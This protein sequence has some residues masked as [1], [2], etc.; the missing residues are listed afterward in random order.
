MDRAAKKFYFLLIDASEA[1]RAAFKK[2]LENTLE[3]PFKIIEASNEIEAI[4]ALHEKSID[5]IILDINLP[6]STGNDFLKT[7]NESVENSI[8]IIIL[9]AH[10]NKNTA[11]T[12]LQAGAKQYL[13][14]SE[15]SDKQLA[16][17]ILN[18]I[19]KQS[20]ESHNIS[21]LIRYLLY[22][23]GLA[24]MLVAGVV[25]YG[26]HI[27][28]VTL[29]QVLPHFPPMQFNTALSF[30]LLGTGILSLNKFPR[31]SLWLAPLVFI[32]CSMT[33]LEY[34]FSTNFGID[35]IFMKPF[36]IANSSNPGRMAPN[37][38]L[39]FM[40]GS[41]ALFFNAENILFRYQ[42]I[43]AVIFSSFI[44]MLGTIAILGYITSIPTAYNWGM[45]TGMNVITA[46]CMTM[47]GIGLLAFSLRAISKDVFSIKLIPLLIALIG[48]V[49]FVMLWQALAAEEDR[50]LAL[51]TEYDANQIK[52]K[53]IDRILGYNISLLHMQKRLDF[54]K[55]ISIPRWEYDAKLYLNNTKA[56]E[57]IALVSNRD[58]TNWH[59]VSSDDTHNTEN[60][61]TVK[62]CLDQAV[63]ANNDSGFYIGIPNESPLVSICLVRYS[64]ED[65]LIELIN[66]PNLLNEG[67]LT[68]NEK[69]YQV[70]LLKNNHNL[71]IQNGIGQVLSS[72]W[73]SAVPLT[74]INKNLELRL[75][76]T[77]K[78]LQIYGFIF[79]SFL[80][81]F[82]IAITLLLALVQYLWIKARQEREHLVSAIKKQEIL[83]MRFQAITV[84]AKDAIIMLDSD[85]RI[86]FWNP[87]ASEIF[88]YT[89]Q[90]VIGNFIYDL[91]IP[92][93]HIESY[94]KEFNHSKQSTKDAIGKTIEITAIK[95]SGMEFPIEISISNVRMQKKWEAIAIV[96]DIT[97]RKNA[98]SIIKH[99]ANYDILT[100][101]PNRLLFSE[102]LKNA[103]IQA[104]KMNLSVS[105]MS[106]DLDGFKPV[107]DLYGHEAGDELLRQ[108]SKR[109]LK[110]VGESNFVAR[111]G[112][113][114]FAVILVNLHY[115][116]EAAMVATLILSALVRPFKIY[117]HTITIGGSIGIVNYPQDATFQKDLIIK[118]DDAMY[119]AKKS[120]KSKFCFFN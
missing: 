65:N 40:L 69:Y 103:L 3:V 51:K 60:L 38:A 106:I 104:D 76:P 112:G 29:V 6:G 61:A 7:L 62:K 2:K 101:L 48:S 12:A 59:I 11:E 77:D 99:Q 100:D 88:G 114:E 33:L 24:I 56:Y 96:R 42:Q 46:S 57:A 63:V 95:N 78:F 17:A 47:A 108:V 43:L 120:G 36:T 39:C 18:T 111:V 89:L 5:C 79:P 15:T 70:S 52:D 30:M 75:W 105:L 107:N 55:P 118:A 23:S 94:K 25:L 86:V 58:S 90:E 45:L 50:K 31:I 1:E 34:I 115:K 10:G 4:R 117:E 116:K 87:A 83:E 19:Q 14:K 28:S 109:L 68:A 91:I 20:L 64:S 84:S 72:D 49:F 44:L 113:D 53:I 110:C 9:T 71:Q 35:L 97:E 16:N 54:Q 98:E 102:L 74:F 119:T 27:H 92:Q 81:V 21:S 8:P 85:D 82:G 80:L 41:A 66:I 73:I 67:L 37:T 13:L 26:W 93:R 22:T 32:L